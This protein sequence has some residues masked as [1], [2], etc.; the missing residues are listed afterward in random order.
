MLKLWK[1]L[2]ISLRKSMCETCGIFCEKNVAGGWWGL[3]LCKI[4]VLHKK[5]HKVFSS[6]YTSFSRVFSPVYVVV[7]HSFH[8]AYYYYNYK[9]LNIY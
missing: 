2:G 4:R 3:V 9:L 7:L 8:I 5:V 6:I 1:K